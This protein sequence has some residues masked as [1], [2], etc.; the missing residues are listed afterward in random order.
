VVGVNKFVID[1]EEP[2]EPLRVDPQIEVEQRERLAALRKQR[3]ND[4]V[5]HAL[6]D[7]R[8]AAAGTDN[9]LLPMRTALEQRATG[10]E[11][12]HAL[13]DVWGVY[14]PHDTF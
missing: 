13:R 12:A 6:D 7:L 8:T 9:V 3:D 14:V 10:G 1:E 11:V 4:A 2:Y 5:R